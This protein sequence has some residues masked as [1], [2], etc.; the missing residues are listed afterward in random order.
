MKKRFSSLAWA[1]LLTC[2]AGAAQAQAPEIKWVVTNNSSLTLSVIKSPVGTGLS[3]PPTLLP[4]ANVGPGGTMTA[5][6]YVQSSDA[7]GFA[8][9]GLYVGAPY[10]RMVYCSFSVATGLLSPSGGLM[11][12]PKPGAVSI[13]GESVTKPNC[14]YSVT[15]GGPGIYTINF[16]FNWS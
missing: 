9:V 11:A 8:Y 2:G 14:A 6:T 10:N 12:A 15:P 16:T 1:S 7:T 3:G 5:T 13:G 4:R